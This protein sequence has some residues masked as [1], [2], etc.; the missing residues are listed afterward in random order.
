M[1]PK[2]KKNTARLIYGSSENPDML[3]TTRFFVPDRFI[4]L[5]HRNKKFIVMSDLEFERAKKQCKG[6]TVL[7]LRSYK[8][9]LRRV[10]KKFSLVNVVD[11]LLKEHR[12]SEI[13]VPE[14]FPTWLYKKLVNNKY[15]VKCSR[16][17][18]F[19]ERAIKNKDEQRAI[20]AIQ[21]VNEKSMEFALK[22]L[23]QAK[24][25]NNKLYLK[26]KPLT[27][28]RLKRALNHFYL[29]NDCTCPEGMIIACGE[30]TALPHHRGS[31]ILLANKPIIIDL[32]PRS[33]KTGYWADMSRT[34]VKGKAQK[35]LKAMYDA[36]L[37][38]QKHALSMIKEGVLASTVHNETLKM[39]GS[40]GFRTGMMSG[41]PQGMIHTT[42]HGLGLEIHENP[43]LGSENKEPLLA[44][45]VV[46]VEPGL[47]YKKIGGI[48]IEDVVIVTK[49]GCRNLT[50]AKKFLELL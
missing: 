48:R 38:S 13:E 5:E 30:Q 41:V 11:T 28:E 42:G 39:L 33:M 50:K 40:H 21:H 23:R 15:K 9:K 20:K 46:T 4:Y 27:S 19:P 10:G 45:N 47:Y 16:D 49:T 12:I 37:A 32:F 36:V 7:S 25:R 8:D 31:G 24:V 3:Y 43:R 44:G 26:G 2:M 34:V 6:C 14:D 17:A 35:K 1:V 22:M 29:D 18:F